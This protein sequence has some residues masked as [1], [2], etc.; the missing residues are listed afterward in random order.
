MSVNFITFGEAQFQCQKRHP[1]VDADILQNFI[2]ERYRRI[3]RRIPWQSMKIQDV[4]ATVAEYT[5]GT[6]S[7][8]LGSDAIVGTGTIWTSA[9][10]GRSIRFGND[11]AYYEFTYESSGVGSLDR[12][13][14]GTSDTDVTYSIW[15]NVFA[16]A[17]DCR[18]LLSI[19]SMSGG[20]DLDQVSM[21]EL[22]EMD[23]KRTLTGNPIR[24]ALHMDDRSTPRNQQVEVHPIPTEVT[25][26]PYW[27]IQDP[28]LFDV[29]D[30]SSYFHPWLNPDVLYSGV[31][32]DVLLREKD[33]AGATL[34]EQKFSI[35]M[36]EMLA[37]ECARMPGV[38][39]Q[40][41]ERFN[42]HRT[43]RGVSRTFPFELP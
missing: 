28:T 41:A 31:A 14:E 9:M 7:V 20:R 1:G 5:T 29:A 19:R 18:D 37:N 40:M 42:R 3:A 38:Q 33:Y 16:L 8:A 34:C 43:N 26:L 27:Y 10:S 22:D 15:K 13:Y 35:G 24:Y 30:T 21:E 12:D 36:N 23:P 39:I 25:A 11:D 17:S 4:I 2:N 32:A 6:V